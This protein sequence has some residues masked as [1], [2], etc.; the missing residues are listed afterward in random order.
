MSQNL[1]CHHAKASYQYRIFLIHD[2]CT[3]GAFIILCSHT[4][5][6]A[7]QLSLN[8]ITSNLLKSRLNQVFDQ[9]FDKSLDKSVDI[10]RFATR[11]AAKWR[12]HLTHTEHHLVT[13][14]SRDAEAI[15]IN[16]VEQQ[17][18]I[19]LSSSSA[20]LYWQA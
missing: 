9:V 2:R 10:F 16:N 14:S 3:Y 5:L 12:Y 20:I 4:C 1:R 13:V 6:L 19:K 8:F 11:F 15:H 17:A 7:N 18:T